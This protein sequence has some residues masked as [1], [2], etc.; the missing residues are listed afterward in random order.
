MSYASK[1]PV[2][3]EGFKE[4]YLQFNDKRKTRKQMEAMA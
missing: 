2:I 3:E 1:L 4:E